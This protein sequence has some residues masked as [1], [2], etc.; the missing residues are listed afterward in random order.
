M[1]HRRQFREDKQTNMKEEKEFQTESKRLLD[2]MINSIYSNQEI[3]LREILSNGSDA[4]DK[5]K[6]LALQGQDKNFTPKDYFL[7]I[8][9]DKK[10]RTLEV[11]DNGIGMDKKEL[12]DN[13]GTIARSGSKDFVSKYEELKKSKDVDLIGQFGVG[14]Y[15]AFMVGKKVEVTTRRPN[16]EAYLFSSEGSEKY[17]IEDVKADE[18]V[19]GTWVKIFLKDDTEETKYSDYLEDYKVEE[20][21][22]KY[23]DYIRYPIKM[24]EI[25]SVPDKDKDGK[26]IEGKSHDVKEDKVLNSMIPLWKKAKGE[27]SDKDL[28]DFY[29]SKFDDYEDPLISLYVKAEGLLSYDAM[30]FIPSHAP[31]NLYSENY[32]K[33]LSLY[34]K[35]IFIQDKCKELVPD[36]LKFAK[37]LVDSDDFPL[38]ISR[39]MLQKSPALTKIAANIEKK[40]LEKL[41]EVKKEDYDKYLKFWKIYGDHIKFG[42]YSS[43]G[44]KKDQLQDLLVFNDLNSDKPVGFKEYKAAMKPE[45][46]YIYYATGKTLEEIKLLPQLEKYRKSG[47]DVLLLKDSI[48]EFCFMMMKEYDK[49]EFKSVSAEDK[50]ELTKEEKDK[51]D[52]LNG[53]YKRILDDVRESLKGK[54]D[55]VSFS[56]KLVDSP[57]CITS[58]EGISLNMEHVIA[59]QPEEKNGAE[60]PKAVK[61]LE[62]NPDHALFKAISGLKDDGEI[63]SYGQLLYDEA[64]ML[65]GYDVEDKTAFVKNLNSLMLKSMGGKEAEKD[66]KTEEAK[67]P[68]EAK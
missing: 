11:R 56:F 38:N 67:K 32:E 14:F 17:T 65:E 33:G 54:I 1:F 31:Y 15:S 58:K 19:S 25:H 10:G 42:I 27:V 35:G 60:A 21:V 22:K 62:I 43:Y 63:K 34:A 40:I 45:Q 18:L 41:A 29:K 28:A 5:Y 59:D 57:V 61:V 13:L 2:L 12:E 26:D 8:I 23:S 46:K 24:E 7:R 64:M 44:M 53:T 36:Y 20:L 48:D 47:V 51:L 68:E 50:E 66:E 37:G 52:L 6:F 16:G 30:I 3:F 9:I 39:E 55:D 4:I 49:T